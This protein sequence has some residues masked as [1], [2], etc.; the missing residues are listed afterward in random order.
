MFAYKAISHTN[1][2]PTTTNNEPVKA[3][4]P[5]VKKVVTINPAAL[6]E[7]HRK[8][9]IGSWSRGN[10]NVV[11]GG[12]LTFEQNGGFYDSKQR[13]GK[14][15]LASGNK[16]YIYYNNGASEVIYLD[17]V[18]EDMMQ[19]S[20]ERFIKRPSVYPKQQ[21]ITSKERHKHNPLDDV[22]IRD[23][24]PRLNPLEE[25]KIK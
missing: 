1:T 15:K 13:T 17:S 2:L 21:A 5:G 23:A 20:N 4:E 22:E 24:K 6:L 16:L 3:S 11:D 9:L 10:G 19:S 18:S 12:V 25:V 7:Q 8:D 14:F